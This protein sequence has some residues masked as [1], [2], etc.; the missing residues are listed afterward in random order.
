[1]RSLRLLSI[2]TAV[3]GSLLGTATA[4]E[5][6]GAEV[7]E[8]LSGKTLYLEFTASITGVNGAGVI[9]YA[10]DGS[11]LYK[12]PKGDLWHG[13]LAIK[14]NTTCI[15]WK[16][17][18]NNACTKYDKQGDSIT[19]INIATGQVRGKIVKTAPGNAEHLSP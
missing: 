14:D 17:Q 16:E 12:T 4:A 2:T 18:P 9:Y 6:S 7:K 19:L 13:T 8:L 15:D 5:L 3:A 1:M 10:P 11:V